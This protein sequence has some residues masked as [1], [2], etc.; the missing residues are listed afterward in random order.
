MYCVARH[1]LRLRVQR[2]ITIHRR[3]A[4]QEKLWLT[5]RS[6]K[7]LIMRCEVEALP[8]GGRRRSVERRRS[9][10]RPGTSDSVAGVS[11]AVGG[12]HL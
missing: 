12:G 3:P 4:A 10:R 5:S 9:S 1:A 6:I 2:Q 11:P 7:N 8:L